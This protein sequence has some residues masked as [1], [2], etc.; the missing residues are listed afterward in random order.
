V[1]Q[2]RFD[3]DQ[4]PDQDPNLYFDADQDPEPI[5]DTVMTNFKCIYLHCMTSA[6]LFD[7]F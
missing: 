3:A 1:D 7:H 6:S 4:D 5:I 2:K